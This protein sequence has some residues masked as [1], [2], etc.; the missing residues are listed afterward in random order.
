MKRTVALT[1]LGVAAATTAF[2]QGGITI[3]NSVPDGAGAYFP[4][5]WD[6]SVPSVGGNAVMGTADGVILTI[7]YG[8]G[9]VGAGA[10]QEGP[11][12]TWNTVFEGLGYF[13][14]YNPTVV[15]TPTGG[16]LYTFQIRASG[17]TPYGPAGGASV[18]FTD[19]PNSLTGTPPP[20]PV[21]SLQR[22]GLNV[23]IVP[24]PTT[25]A[26]AGLG[27]AALLIFRRRD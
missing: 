27:A 8:V 22:I 24:E 17:E 2:G 5:L 20:P 14:Y 7:W 15:N 18:L 10:L 1:I 26:L 25:F 9:D 3:N 13:G 12:A 11:V 6:A 19:T 21:D 16:E 4:V 23:Q